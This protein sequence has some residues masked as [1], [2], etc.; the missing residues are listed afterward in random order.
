MID[1]AK[2]EMVNSKVNGYF[3]VQ[4]TKYTSK[5][6]GLFYVSLLELEIWDEVSIEDLFYQLNSAVYS[7]RIQ[8]LQWYLPKNTFKGSFLRKIESTK[9]NDNTLVLLTLVISILELCILFFNILS[10]KGIRVSFKVL[11][12]LHSRFCWVSRYLE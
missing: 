10:Y 4:Q 1:N 3:H 6:I 2:F 5:E 7:K 12:N 9:K 8:L 11:S